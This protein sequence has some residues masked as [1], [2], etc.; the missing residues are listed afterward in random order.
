[1]RIDYYYIISR[2]NQYQSLYKYR[3]LGTDQLRDL[4]VYSTH[5]REKYKGVAIYKLEVHSV[6]R[7]VVLYRVNLDDKLDLV[8]IELGLL[9][10][11]L[12]VHLRVLRLLARPL[13]LHSAVAASNIVVRT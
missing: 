2:I 12:H 5:A 3:S 11:R 9:L 7:G 13:S 4:E 6:A 10:I 1:M 8:S